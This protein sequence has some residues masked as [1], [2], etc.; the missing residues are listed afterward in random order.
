MKQPIVDK[1]EITWFQVQD[2]RMQSST[3]CLFNARQNECT[4]Y[5]YL[6]NAGKNQS[7]LTAERIVKKMF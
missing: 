3:Y 5:Y 2:A 7:E 1:D 4:V 6:V